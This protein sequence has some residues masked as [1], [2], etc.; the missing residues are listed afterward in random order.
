MNTIEQL[1]IEYFQAFSDKDIEKL[2]SIF[3]DSIHL[4]DWEVDIKGIDSVL[5]FNKKLFD[6]VNYIKVNPIITATT[7]NTSLSKIKVEV[8]SIVLKVVDIITFEKD[9]IIKIEAFKQ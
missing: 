6:Q 7:E 3:S 9:K 4:V 1:T 8:D 2:K 5:N